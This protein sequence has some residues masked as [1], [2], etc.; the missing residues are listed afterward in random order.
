[1]VQGIIIIQIAIFVWI[2]GVFFASD[3][4]GKRRDWTSWFDKSA[5]EEQTA[6]P[7]LGMGLL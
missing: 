7:I 5:L 6:L 3:L 1:M 4:I 2:V